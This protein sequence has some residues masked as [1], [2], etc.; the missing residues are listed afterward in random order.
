MAVR[1]K[2]ERQG[3]HNRNRA[4]CPQHIRGAVTLHVAADQ[5]LDDHSGERE[6]HSAGHTRIHRVVRGTAR[7]VSVG[8]RRLPVLA[9]RPGA[10]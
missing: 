10:S 3:L 9:D 7:H 8:G 5:H 1:E 6:H 4:G 2:K